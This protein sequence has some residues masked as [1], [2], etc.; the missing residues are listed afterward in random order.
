MKQKLQGYEGSSGESLSVQG[1]VKRL[2][3]EAQSHEN[4]C[5]MYHGWN[6]AW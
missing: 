1:Q 2:I 5:Q 6:P 4:L 3:A